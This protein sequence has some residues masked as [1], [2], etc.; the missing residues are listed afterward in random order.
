MP[1]THQGLQ[2]ASPPAA[3]VPGPHGVHEAAPSLEEEPAVHKLQP[4]LPSSAA[5]DPSEH[6]LH[7]GK[8]AAS[9]NV[10]MAQRV[11]G[12]PSLEL[13]P[14]AHE[15]HEVLPFLVASRPAGQVTQALP[16]ELVPIPDASVATA[17][18][19]EPTGHVSHSAMPSSPLN[20]PSGHGRHCDSATA[21]A[22]AL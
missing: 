17:V 1:T 14:T 13:S 4:L 6:G 15:V 11:H 18:T 10:P 19:Y 8:A 7:E 22:S 2:Y 16:P 12:S 9:A 5:Y 20:V 3:A 21:P